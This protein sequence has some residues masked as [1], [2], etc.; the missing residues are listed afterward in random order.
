MMHFEAPRYLFVPYYLE[1]ESGS[2]LTIAKQTQ[3]TNWNSN[4]N[5]DLHL[6][7]LIKLALVRTCSLLSFKLN[8]VLIVVPLS[9]IV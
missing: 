4:P 2:Q 8:F 9:V 1:S 5:P 3:T 7:Q 6:P